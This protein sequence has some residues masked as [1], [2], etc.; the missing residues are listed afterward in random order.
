MTHG[1]LSVIFGSAAALRWANT[2]QF[3][4]ASIFL[5]ACASINNRPAEI[6]TY[7]YAD[8]LL[9]RGSYEDAHDAYSY[10]A[11]TYPKSHLTEEA[12]F[13]AAYILVYYKNPDRDYDGRSMI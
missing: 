1:L 9:E 8:V 2:A 13:Q 5:A 7:D 4:L 3:F 10:L 6:Q 11:E 12:E